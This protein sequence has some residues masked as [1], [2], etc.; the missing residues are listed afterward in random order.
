MKENSPQPS[1]EVFNLEFKGIEQALRQGNT[2]RAFCSV[3]GLRVVRIDDY[4]EKKLVG[5]GEHPHIEDALRHAE[6][7]FIVGGLPY[8][9]KYGDGKKYPE[10]STG[11]LTP[12]SEL[13]AIILRG[14]TFKAF[15]TEKSKFN[16]AI[17]A[18]KEH[19]TPKAILEQA[20]IMGEP[21]C[22][23]D[24]RGFTFEVT[25]I[26]G[27]WRISV[28][29]VPEGKTKNDGYSYRA[30]KIGQGRSFKEAVNNA[31]KAPETE[32]LKKK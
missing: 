32:I 16:F 11:S 17:D 4:K 13:D 28:I 22:Y 29:T 8:E 27:G 7:D 9:E 20:R 26:D 14:S 2:L 15:C 21:I 5:Y 23:Q 10:Y 19:E 3:G 31:F 25:N 24:A 6:E 18:Y 1:P 12:S 30:T